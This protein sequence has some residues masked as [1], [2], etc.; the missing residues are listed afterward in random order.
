MNNEASKSRES[1]W[2]R[3]LTAA[4]RADLRAQPDLALEA[5]LTAALEKIPAAPV[6]SNFT[7]RLLET[8]ERE[9]KSAAR[10]RGRW[11]WRSE[12]VF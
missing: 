3:K 6:P 10:S 5:Q 8:I 2:R 4:A 7:A 1:L 12:R 11:H 9:E